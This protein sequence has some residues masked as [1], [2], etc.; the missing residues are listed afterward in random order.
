MSIIWSDNDYCILI[1]LRV[2]CVK[3]VYSVYFFYTY[4]HENL[5]K[6]YCPHAFIC[7]LVDLEN[8]NEVEV[9]NS[10]I[11][12][13]FHQRICSL[14][15]C[16]FGTEL[17]IQWHVPSG[18]SMTTFIHWVSRIMHLFLRLLCLPRL[19]SSH[20]SMTLLRWMHL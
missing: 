14:V 2:I 15:C 4:L 18:I 6:S 3:D 19:L 12:S 9:E 8:T 5:T 17:S 20:H 10:P 13:Y 1:R 7:Q 11:L 16:S